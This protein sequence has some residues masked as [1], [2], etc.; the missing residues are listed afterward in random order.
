MSRNLWSQADGAAAPAAVG[1]A[2]DPARKAAMFP[3]MWMP[4][5]EEP[6]ANDNTGC[7]TKT[8]L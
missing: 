6:W 2:G 1:S 5:P 7:Y 3:P 4:R 8:R